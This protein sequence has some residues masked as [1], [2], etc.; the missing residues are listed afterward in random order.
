MQE[1]Q[2]PA[3]PLSL[4][5][6]IDQDSIDPAACF[7][8]EAGPF[9]LEALN[10]ISRPYRCREQGTTVQAA[11]SAAS[12]IAIAQAQ[13]KTRALPQT[14]LLQC[15]ANMRRQVSRSHTR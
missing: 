4:P 9:C 5:L 8:D 6:K 7:G 1:A 12:A 13:N 14:L 15:P 11:V 3:V 2:L 10:A